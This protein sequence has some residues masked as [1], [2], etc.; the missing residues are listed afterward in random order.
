MA[1]P[2]KRLEPGSIVEAVAD[3]GTLLGTGTF[4]PHSLIAVRLLRQRARGPIDADF[5]RARIAGALRLRGALFRQP[6]FR[7]IHAE[8][9]GLGG[10]V[11]DRFGD[12]LSVQ[13][14]TAGMERL[15]MEWQAAL[16]AEL[17]PR[18]IILRNDNPGRA[19]EG[20]PEA[21]GVASGTLSGTVIV[22]EGACRFEA[23]L[24]GGQ[25]TGWYFDQRDWHL[26]MAPLADGGR[27]LDAYCYAGGFGI[28]ALMA[29]AASVTFVDSS[30][31]A[32]D[33]TARNI[34]LSGITR[35]TSLV[36]A[37]A[38][39]FM[40]R[41]A[42]QTRF[43]IV[44]AD[45][46][47]FIRSRKDLEA[48]A[49]GYRKLARLAAGLV[50]SGGFLYLASCSH[51]ISMERFAEECA[52]GISRAGRSARIIASGGAAPDHPV[53]PHLPESA[54]LKAIVYHLE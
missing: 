29:G 4:N 18:A 11:V 24:L 47:P 2:V 34:A 46:P 53:H 14:N 27:V 15:Q 31:G 33:L 13:V 43:D 50:T 7:L 52:A 20:L 25:K 38:M 36:R 37:D 16:I 12:V 41:E 26:F 32:L 22:E 51:A 1:L 8:A 48:G 17:N 39:E 10:L 49:K 28:H 5:F 45:P 42:P 19:L 35:P 54:Y 40:E 3:D 23:D 30:Q 21:K 6:F 44:I 9:D